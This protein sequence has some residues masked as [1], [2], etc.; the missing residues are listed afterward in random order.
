M[1]LIQCWR[2]CKIWRYLLSDPLFSKTLISRTPCCLLVNGFK[3]HF[4][5]DLNQK[6]SG[7]YNVGVVR[8]TGCSKAVTVGSCNG[9][10]CRYNAILLETT[11]EF[12]VYNPMTGEQLWVVPS[13]AEY[14]SFGFGYSPINSAYKIVLFQLSVG[15]V[16]KPFVTTVMTVGSG[17]WRCVKHA[18][19]FRSCR[20]IQSEWIYLNGFLHSI[21]KGHD[22]THS[23]IAFDV[24]SERFQ[25]L[26]LPQEFPIDPKARLISA[27]GVSEG[28]L[29]V[30]IA[31]HNKMVVWIMKDYGIKESW[32]RDFEI[33]D[34]SHH[35][36]KFCK[37]LNYTQGR[38][39][40]LCEQQ[41]YTYTSA[42]D[43]L[44]RVQVDRVP[45]IDK[46]WIHIPSF[47]SFPYVRS[48]S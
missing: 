36:L 39:L 20:V 30:T 28:R 17:I 48:Q 14:N 23:I 31:S 33:R 19:V 9:F 41:L 35:Q 2:V 11:G 47:I 46:A 40:L 42:I 27:V 6:T 10:V 3:G 8:L 45:A 24:E 29:Y 44:V 22:G 43:C 13:E 21:C 38:A 12:S 37:L 34:D 26:L 16:T 25:R 4:L 7:E 1:S 32:T 15:E 18:L 5:V